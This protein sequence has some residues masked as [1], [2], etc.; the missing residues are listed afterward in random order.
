MPDLPTWGE[1]SDLDKGAAL[2]HLHKRDV[3]GVSYATQHYPCRY[4][5]SD[6]LVA[7]SPRDASLHAADVGA[8]AFDGWG[9]E[10]SRLYDLALAE[11]ERRYKAAQASKEN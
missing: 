4:L 10:G 11:D 7:L 9:D 1:M 2:M 6:V 5:D 8:A 3:E